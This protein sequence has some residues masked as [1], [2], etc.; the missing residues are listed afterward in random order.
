MWLIDRDPV[1]FLLQKA[2]EQNFELGK[3]PCA[4]VYIALSRHGFFGAEHQLTPFL[5]FQIVIMV[6]HLLIFLQIYQTNHY[7]M[8]LDL[9]LWLPSNQGFFVLC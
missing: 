7:I 9:L 6:F 2:Q 3:H 8:P 1:L 4:Q 5:L